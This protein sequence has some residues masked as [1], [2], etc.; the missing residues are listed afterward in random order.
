MQGVLHQ[1]LYYLLQPARV[2]RQLFLQGLHSVR[3]G[4]VGLDLILLALP[5]Q[6]H[7]VLTML[8]QG[9][10]E[11]TLKLLYHLLLLLLVLGGPR[12]ERLRWNHPSQPLC[13]LLRLVEV[14]TSQQQI[15]DYPDQV[16]SLGQDESEGVH[17]LSPLRTG[18]RPH[19]RGDLILPQIRIEHSPN[20]FFLVIHLLLVGLSLTRI[21]LQLE[22]R[23]VIRLNC[24]DPPRVVDFRKQIDYL[25][26][27]VSESPLVV[28]LEMVRAGVALF[29][30]LRNRSPRPL[31]ATHPHL[32]LPLPTRH[33]HLLK[34]RLHPF[35]VQRREVRRGLPDRSLNHSLW[36]I[37]IHII[38][39]QYRVIHRVGCI[40]VLLVLFNRLR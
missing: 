33:H 2:C 11:Q 30:P 37:I 28:V 16:R 24:N 7:L 26:G 1:P 39:G 12:P 8:P 10:R 31:R 9:L 13:R 25:T 35:L 32:I 22:I 6:F 14:H 38:V 4:L 18:C 27:C 23:S 36:V 17:S 40:P 5:S 3:L 20:H 15:P 19:I 21:Y 29:L 34:G